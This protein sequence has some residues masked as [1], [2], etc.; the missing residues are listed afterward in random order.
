MRVILG[1]L[2]HIWSKMK[3]IVCDNAI[4]LCFQKGY[5]FI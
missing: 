3:R 4:V 1:K 2:V 5:S